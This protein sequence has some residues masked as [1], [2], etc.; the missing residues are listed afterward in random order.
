VCLVHIGLVTKSQLIHSFTTPSPHP[1][2]AQTPNA[3]Q[4]VGISSETSKGKTPLV[5]SNNPFFVLHT[6]EV[7]EP[8]SDP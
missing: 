6:D 7:A 5:A 2:L 3:V 4:S 8:I 1:A